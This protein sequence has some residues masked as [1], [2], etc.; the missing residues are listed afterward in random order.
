MRIPSSEPVLALLAPRPATEAAP[1]RKRKKKTS[2]PGTID[3]DAWV[4][5]GVGF[6]LAVIA[7]AVPRIGFFIHV[8]MTVIH[9]LGHT[10]TAWLFASPALPEFRLF[11]LSGRHAI[12]V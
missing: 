1:K 6:G 12:T 11:R 7:L 9:E 2:K 8:L 5:L 3:R 4:S 10:A